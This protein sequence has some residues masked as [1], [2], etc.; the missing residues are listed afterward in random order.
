MIKHEEKNIEEHIQHYIKKDPQDRFAFVKGMLC[1]NKWNF[2]KFG[3]VR[4]SLQTQ[5]LVKPFI[6]ASTLEWISST[7]EEPFMDSA[8]MV[9]FALS[10]PL[11]SIISH[12]IWEYFCFQMIEVGHRAHTSLK[13]MLF[14]K[15]FRMT[16]ATNKDFSSGEVSHII[17]GESNRIWDFIWTAPDFFECPLH[18]ITA[19]IVVFQLIGWYGMIVVV[20]AMA[21]LFRDY[22]RGKTEKDISEKQRDKKTKRTL[23]IS[24][25]F[26]NIKTVKLYGWEQKF[27]KMINDVYEEELAIGDQALLRHKIYDIVGGILHNFTSIA[28]IGT[29]YY[30]GNTLTLG[31]LAL[32]TVMMNR[33]KDRIFHSKHLFDRYFDT[34]ESM[35]KLWEYYCAPET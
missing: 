7:E 15:N 5:E 4:L 1:A 31:E 28:T 26:N 16:N 35:E 33:I 8:R 13:V 34:M 20:F 2:A 14:R 23:H 25:S 6:I 21:I 29:Y 11:L 19:A 30:F 10:I 32:C 27:S 24:E 18:L 3:L 9:M 12:T 22:L 17:M